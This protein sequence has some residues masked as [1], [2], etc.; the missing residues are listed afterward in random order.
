M[1]DLTKY[2]RHKNILGAG[3]KKRVKLPP[4]Q[5]FKVVMA[6]YGKGTLHS[7]SGDIVTNFKQALAIAYSESKKAKKN[8][9]R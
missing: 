4:K 5:K 1:P 8:W 6:E 7:G 3:A 9:K 2:L